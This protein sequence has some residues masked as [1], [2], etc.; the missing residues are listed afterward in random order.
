M[1]NF[2][3]YSNYYDLLY[4]DKDYAR[5]VKFLEK[6][7]KEYSF[8]PVKDILSLGCGTANHEVILAQKG[9]NIT[10]LDKS[11][12]MIELAKKK[13]SAIE[14]KV[15]DVK[16]FKIDK[17]FDLAMA[18]FNVIGYQIEGINKVLT[19]VSDCL[20][21][22]GLFIFDCWYAPAVLKNRPFDKVKKIGEITRVTKQKLDVENKILNINFE[23]I[24]KGKSILKEEHRMRFWFLPELKDLLEESGF[25]LIKSCNFL[26]LDSEVSEDNWNIFIIAKKI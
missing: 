3:K 15:A 13:T 24:E 2:K 23:I 8:L 9:Y 4:K 25:Q 21:D 16:D 12:E 26:D 5:E 7:I 22:K 20:K 11:E 10:G 6:V 18:M 14:F 1:E 17:K 19:N